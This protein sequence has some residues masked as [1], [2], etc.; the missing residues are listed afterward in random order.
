MDQP[1]SVFSFADGTL[2]DFRRTP[3]AVHR[4]A[5]AGA[6]E[7]PVQNLWTMNALTEALTAVGELPKSWGELVASCRASFDRLA[8]GT[9]VDEVLN[10]QPFSLQVA[11]R[12]YDLLKVLQT[13]MIEMNAEGKLSDRGKELHQTFFVGEEALFSDE[14]EGNKQKFGREM[15]FPDPIV[16]GRD[17]TCF[18]HGKI[19]SPQFRIH[20]EWPA[21]PP[22]MKVAYI[23]P[24]I[25]KR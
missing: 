18:W 25:S 23:G 24:K 22:R 16:P 10:S 11:R 21:R 4:E 6:S 19:Q 14:S 5:H 12:I 7:V 8:V 3:L 2:A 20:F 13:L 1:A 15:T 9:H 17:I